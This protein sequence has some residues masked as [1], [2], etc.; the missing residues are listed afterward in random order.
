MHRVLF[1]LHFLILVFVG[2][3]GGVTVRLVEEQQAA[4]VAALPPV[5]YGPASLSDVFID[6]GHLGSGGEQQLFFDRRAQLLQAREDFVEVDL[7]RMTLTLYRGGEALRTFPVLSKGRDGSWWETPTGL[8]SVRAK[9][10]N[11]YSTIGDVWMPWSVQFYGNFLIHGW[12]YY[13]GGAPVPQ[14]YSGG[15]VR[16]SSEDAEVVFGF[17]R[18]D[19]PILV[20]DRES[21]PAPLPTLVMAPDAP[22]IPLLSGAA[23]FATDLDTGA[24]LVDLRSRDVLPVASLVKLMTVTVA[25]EILYLGRYVTVSSDMVRDGIQ[26][27][28]LAVGESYRLFDLLYPA[29]MK[30]SNGAA[31]ALRGFFSESAFVSQMNEK[32]MSLGMRDTVFVDSS[33][34]GS[35]N[36]STLRDMAKLAKYI[37][38]KRVFLFSISRGEEYRVFSGNAF[39]GIRNYNEFVLDDRLIGVKNGFT[40]AA[41]ETLLTVWQLRDTHEHERHIMIAVLGSD[42]RER[43]VRA[44]RAWLGASFGL[45]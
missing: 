3:W 21:E 12:P 40:R 39:P 43:D 4:A 1:L 32:A 6:G 18:P 41:G 19:M 7:Q 44:I 17:A 38:D 14:G 13:P 24:V 31:R 37:L 28:P 29:L 16:L 8:Y 42:D 15:C 33:G 22:G 27:H 5:V 20:F 30:S 2:L 11:L 36:V 25:S 34:V 35:G 10:S 26:S 45:Q 9:S 23:A